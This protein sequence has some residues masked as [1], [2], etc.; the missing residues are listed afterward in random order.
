MALLDLIK[1]V[2]VQTLS[3]E[4]HPARKLSDEDKIH[5]LN[6]LAI[7]A[8]IDGNIDEREKEYLTI[9]LNS[10][11]LSDDLLESAIDFAKNPDE[12]TLVDMIKS[13]SNKNIKYTFLIDAM[14][15][16]NR[17]GI[18][19]ESEKALIDEYF[20]MFKITEDEKKDLKYIFKLFYTQD[21]N[22]LYRHF[23]K[24]YRYKPYKINPKIF[25]Y[26]LEYY[27]IDMKYELK[28]EEEKILDFKFFEP[29]LGGEVSNNYKIMEKPVSNAQFVI[30]L[31]ALLI[32]S[33]IEV[34]DNKVFDAKTKTL[35]M[36]LNNSDI[37]YIDN[38]FV[39]DKQENE[40]NRI[41]GI[42]YNFASRFIGWV[43]KYKNENY[44]ILR[45]SARNKV[46][47]AYIN[48][49][50][51]PVIPNNEFIGIYTIYYD[52]GNSRWEYSQYKYVYMRNIPNGSFKLNSYTYK[53]NDETFNSKDV[54]F[55]MI[56]NKENN[57]G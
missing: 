43:S 19:D 42:T 44:E 39:V 14:I 22:G 12:Q 45:F 51:F 3:F 4:K 34:E 13:F 15:I 28:K 30:F 56:K 33:L 48:V 21:G 24:D 55:R 50:D 37:E 2:K 8:N 1:K 31:N 20:D 10:F 41:T 36:D 29:D 26:L 6:G 25:E 54:S 57:K 17:D 52:S 53:G 23:K 35:L 32:D 16:A 18:F 38:K 5:Y 11:D 40:D 7:V 47:Y 46:N 27:G 9:L 49:K